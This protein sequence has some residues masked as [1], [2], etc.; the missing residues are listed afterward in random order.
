MR[1]EIFAELAACLER[2]ELVVLATV[3]EGEGQ[4]RQMLIWPRGETYGDLGS[5]RLNQ[6]A[7]LY[8]EQIIPDLQSGRKSFRR[9]AREVDVFFEVYP[10]PAEIVVI[11]AVH[12]AVPLIGFAK[13]LGFRTIVIDPRAAFATEE[14]F[15]H[16]DL[17]VN[18]WPQ[19]AL[20]EIQLHE[21]SCLVV[22]SHDMKIDLPALEAGLRSSC[23]YLGALGSRKTHAKRV[24][25]LIDSGFSKEE[26]G[27]IHAPIGLDLGGRMA[28]EIA[29]AIMAE[30]LA[31]GYGRPTGRHLSD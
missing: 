11:G 18:L 15:E 27:R 6:R 5:P 31:A 1:R 8:A 12:L 2:R 21:A 30:I 24:T 25:A 23:R 10:P 22:L 17:V 3:V 4:G 7:A 19:E 29:L 14:R 28:E 9:Q 13:I 20:K 16:A 26:I